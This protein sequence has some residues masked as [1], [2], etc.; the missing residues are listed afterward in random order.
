MGGCVTT[1]KKNEV[2]VDGF[3][4]E[5]YDQNKDG[6]VV[7]SE[8]EAQHQKSFDV[9]DL[10]KNGYVEK[11]EYDTVMMASLMSMAKKNNMSSSQFAN[12]IGVY[13]KGIDD[14]FKKFDKNKDKKLSFK[15]LIINK[16]KKVENFMS[17]DLNGDKKIE[18]DELQVSVSSKVMKALGDMKNVTDESLQKNSQSKK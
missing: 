11:S 1:Q 5:Q 16:D 18:K 15:E 10:N 12:A 6:F 17:N 13:S 7:E 2:K 3:T 14:S 8:V 4:F 9:M